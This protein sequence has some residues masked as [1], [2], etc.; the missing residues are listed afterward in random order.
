MLL[1][2]PQV[3]SLRAAVDAGDTRIV[4]LRAGCSYRQRLESLLAKRGVQAPRLLEFGTIEAIFK[5]V[6]AGLGITLLPRSVVDRM[7]DKSDVGIHTLPKSEALVQTLFIRRHDAFS[8]SALAAFLDCAR[9]K[10][11]QARAS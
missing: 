11:A 1:S 2:A 9:A 3:K 7:R 8:S 10:P 4:V 5:C 6:A